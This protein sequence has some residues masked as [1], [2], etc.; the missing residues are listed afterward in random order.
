MCRDLDRSLAGP[1]I[2][3]TTVIDKV[4]SILVP[5]TRCSVH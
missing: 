3:M 1:L 5:E 4:R 2:R